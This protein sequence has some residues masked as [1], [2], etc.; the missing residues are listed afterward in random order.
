MRRWK[1]ITGYE[2]YYE[3][4]DDGIVRSLDRDIRKSNGVIQ[5]RNGKNKTLSKDKDGYLTVNLSK[6]GKDCR[7]HV[8]V[9]VAKEFV[10]G[11][12]DGLE[13]NHKDFDRTNN[14]YENL[15]WVTH[16]DN[17]NHS[18][19]SGRYSMRDINGI[20]NP[21]YGNSI[22]RE[23]YRKD[24]ELSKLKNSR[25]GSQNGRSRPIRM[26][27]SDG[28]YLDFEYM[29]ECA[30]Y[31]IKNRLVRSSDTNSVSAYIS[32]AARN[33]RHYS[34]YRFEFI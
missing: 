32:S 16:S 2:N 31:M 19:K 14:N 18:S 28:L 6:D 9:L 17:V 24:K 13:V 8:H 26:F 5:H 7:Y 27:V 25:P 4:S 20:H 10:N 15:E 1:P 3:I 11:Y 33:N 30:N 29:A 22:L 12:C 34:G 23:I 21:N